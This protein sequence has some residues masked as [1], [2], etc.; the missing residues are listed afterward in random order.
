MTQASYE[1]ESPTEIFVAVVWEGCELERKHRSIEA[2]VVA[3]HAEGLAGPHWL[4]A[5]RTKRMTQD[6]APVL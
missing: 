3:V 6:A 4:Q 5:E 2:A 1:T